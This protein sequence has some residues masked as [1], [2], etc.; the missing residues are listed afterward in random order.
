MWIYHKIQGILSII[1]YASDAKWQRRISESRRD[2]EV[3]RATP[4]LAEAFPW[5][6]A[7]A[8][9]IRQL[10]EGSSVSWCIV[11][12][13]IVH[14]S[15]QLCISRCR[16]RTCSNISLSETQV[17]NVTSRRDT[18]LRNGTFVPCFLRRLWQDPLFSFLQCVIISLI[19]KCESK[20]VHEKQQSIKK[21]QPNATFTS[22]KYVCRVSA[23]GI[24]FSSFL[25]CYLIPCF[26]TTI[27]FWI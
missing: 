20:S 8:E 12:A 14:A 19:C 13:K 22:F 11:C 1:F 23:L 18:H 26:Y 25:Y 5:R 6:H 2:C 15:R 24:D 3:L 10:K 27:N 21:I 16:T 9:E 4:R 17:N 7:G